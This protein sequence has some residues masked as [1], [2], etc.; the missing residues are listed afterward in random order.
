MIN[1]EITYGNKS[2][3]AKVKGHAGFAPKGQDIVCAGVSALSMALYKSVVHSVAR[4]NTAYFSVEINDGCFEM[5]V[6]GIRDPETQK[7]LEM[8][9]AMFY[10]GLSEIEK[11][12]PDYIKLNMFDFPFGGNDNDT[13][14]QTMKTE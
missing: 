10:S 6:F 11:Q 4:E 3:M 12:Y 7:Q 2:F 1:A 8:F 14:E 9:L 13:S 5:R